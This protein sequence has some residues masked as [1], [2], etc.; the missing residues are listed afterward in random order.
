ML[1]GLSQPGGIIIPFVADSASGMS[2]AKLMC[3]KARGSEKF[4]RASYETARRSF[5][6]GGILSVLGV[7][8]G[9]F[10]EQRQPLCRK[11]IEVITSVDCH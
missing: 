9:A 6:C 7:S 3:D 2:I 4:S 8:N 5:G 1:T 11:E 10:L